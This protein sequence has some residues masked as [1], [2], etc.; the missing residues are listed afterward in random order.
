MYFF[1]P[2]HKEASNQINIWKLNGTKQYL[3][4]FDNLLYLQFVSQNPL[5]SEA[6]K[7]QA[8]AEIEVAMKKLAF[9]RR[10]P[11]YD[12]DEALRGVDQLRKQ[13]SSGDRLAA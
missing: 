2:P 3:K 9:W 8:R 6:E 12:H 1:Y 13:W 10:H 5:A 4:H 11:N 7:R